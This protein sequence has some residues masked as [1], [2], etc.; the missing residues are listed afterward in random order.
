MTCSMCALALCTHN[1]AIVFHYSDVKV[2]PAESHPLFSRSWDSH[3]SSLFKSASSLFSLK[4]CLLANNF[5]EYFAKKRSN[6]SIL[7]WVR[8]GSVAVILPV[9]MILDNDMAFIALMPSGILFAGP[10]GYTGITFQRSSPLHMVVMI[11]SSCII[12]QKASSRKLSVI[13]K[14]T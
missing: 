12:W 4:C 9:Y 5:F 8:M 2:V 7:S 3:N 1:A 10:V 11:N 14:K 6:R 13:N